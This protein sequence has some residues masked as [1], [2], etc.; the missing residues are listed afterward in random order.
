[1]SSELGNA[2]PLSAS[3]SI[4]AVEKPSRGSDHGREKQG[5]RGKDG[6]PDKKLKEQGG[7]NSTRGNEPDQEK[8]LH[9]DAF[10]ASNGGAVITAGDEAIAGKPKRKMGQHIDV[11][12]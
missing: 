5:K 8:K 6:K 1:M 12:I 9:E 7:S 4:Q 2:Q 3:Q 11:K 10:E